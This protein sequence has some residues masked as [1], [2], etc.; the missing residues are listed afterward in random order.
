MAVWEKGKKEMNDNVWKDMFGSKKFQAALA[1]VVAMVCNSAF[2]WNVSQETLLPILGI[3]AVYIVG[4]GV[5]DIGKEKAKVDNG[6]PS[7]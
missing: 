4:Q 2:E 1:T 5:A 6:K 7:K 3:I